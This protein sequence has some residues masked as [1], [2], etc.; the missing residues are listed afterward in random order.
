MRYLLLGY[1]RRF[2]YVVN[3]IAFCDPVQLVLLGI[4]EGTQTGN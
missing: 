2:I 1:L 4:S 3:R